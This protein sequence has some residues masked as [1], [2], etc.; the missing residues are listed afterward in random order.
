MIFTEGILMLIKCLY[1]CLKMG[2]Q[3]N[4]HQIYLKKPNILGLKFEYFLDFSVY[5]ALC[6]RAIKYSKKKNGLT[7]PTLLPLPN[8]II[9]VINLHI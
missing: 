3:Q 9:C 8:D 1:F 2:A 4:N 7:H 5:R 6:I